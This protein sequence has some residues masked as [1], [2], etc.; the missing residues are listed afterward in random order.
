MYYSFKGCIGDANVNFKWAFK[1]GPV[2]TNNLQSVF[3]L[4]V[5]AFARTERVNLVYPKFLGAIWVVFLSVVYR[6]PH[7]FEQL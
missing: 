2:R 7:F 6:G 3:F 1:S 5:N 4:D